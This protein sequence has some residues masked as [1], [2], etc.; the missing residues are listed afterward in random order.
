V[1]GEFDFWPGRWDVRWDGGEGT[2]TITRELGGAV[3]LERFESADLQGLSVTV[4]DGT[5]WRQ[6][7]VDGNHTYLDFRGGPVGDEVQLVHSSENL[8]MRFTEIDA[9]SLVWLWERRVDEQWEL[10]WR[11]DYARNGS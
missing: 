8:R 3:L 7:W 4:H 10:A 1:N 6:T 5:E 2:N 9:D 11:I